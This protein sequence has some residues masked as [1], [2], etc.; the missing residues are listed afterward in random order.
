MEI[1]D[2]TLVE[3]CQQGDQA[4]FRALVERYQRKVFNL[5][6]GMVR[7]PDD[8][9]ELV[10][11]AFVKAYRN[12]ER[13]Q[14]S[15]SF[16]T[17][18]YRITVNVC[19]DFIRRTKKTA[20][21]LDYDDRVAHH[22]EVNQGEFPLVSSMGTETPSRVQ[23]RRELGEQIQRAL[24]G[25][26]EAHR[27]IVLLREVEGLSYSE[28]AEALDIPKGTVMSRLFHARQNLQ[29]VLRP[30]VERGEAADLEAEEG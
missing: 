20:A 5:A 9:M 26:S 30:Y 25:L 14:G 17:W 18:L 27:E 21:P 24:E 10:Q 29:R 8:A 1:D 11:E 2:T 7:N 19:I 12:L 6:Y 28:I 23:G 4:A 13:F 15:S 22:E 16:Y 3:R